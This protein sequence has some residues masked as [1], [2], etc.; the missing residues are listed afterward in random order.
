MLK[1][2]LDITL[3]GIM[4]IVLMPLWLSL[5]LLIGIFEGPPVL[6]R[7]QRVGR[8]GRIFTLYKFR[9]M[10]RGADQVGPGVTMGSDPRVTRFGGFL[11]RS[12][13]DEVPQLLN[14]LCGDMSLV[15][16][17]PEDP[18]FVRLYSPA[19]RRVLE[20][21]PGITSPASLA[22]RHEQQQ[23]TGRT[24]RD[25]VE[26][27]LP[28]KLALELAYLRKSSMASDLWVMLRTAA[29][30]L[31][32]DALRSLIRRYPRSLI[33]R[34]LPWIVID[35]IT[36]V[37]AF[38][39]ALGIRFSEATAAGRP[40][41]TSALNLVIAPLVILFLLVN[42]S[43]G[44]NR[45]VWSYASAGEVM[46]VLNSCA[47][48]T[49]LAVAVD[50][51]I[52]GFMGGR[53]LPL[54]VIVLGGFFTFT[55]IIVTRYRSRLIQAAWRW[56]SQ[57][58]SSPTCTLIYGAGEAGQFVAWRLLH[59]PQGRVY[60]VVGLIDDDHAKRG[61]RVHGLSV[62]GSRDQLHSI[63]DKYQVDLVIL[64]ISNISGDSL[65][66]IV[67]TCQQT[68]A[69]IKIVPNL[70]D[71]M[72]SGTGPLVREITIEDLL[73]RP[74]AAI[75]RNACASLLTGQVVLVT[76]GS[77]SVGSELCRQI[78]SFAPT[79]LVVL[80][81]NES[82]LYD[83]GIELQTSYP[84]LNFDLVVGDVTDE[85][86]MDVILARSRPSVVFHAAA[87]KHVPLMQAF[88]DQ[89]VRANV[90]GTRVMLEAA[91]RHSIDRFVL[92]STDKAVNPTSA[93]GA[94][95]RVAE[96]LVLASRGEPGRTLSTVV[97]F[98][99]VL[100]S[101]GSVV[102]TFARQIELGGP[103][104]V[105]DPEMTRFFMEISDAASLIILAATLTEGGDIFMLEM[106]KRIR[107]D[108]LARKMIRLRGLRPDVDIPI[109]Y[110]G[111]RPGEKFDE[112]LTL[113]GESVE[114]TEHPMIYRVRTTATLA[115][116]HVLDEID[117]LLHQVDHLLRDTLVGDDGS[118]LEHLLALA[119]APL[120]LV[121]TSPDRRQALRVTTRGANTD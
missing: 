30:I 87:Y 113:A 85:R 46:L 73:G 47:T 104:T 102:P 97:R 88:P 75:N 116:H 111:V 52:G 27:A 115:Q 67:D 109:V 26:Q 60:R 14:V 92:V 12:K 33:R 84:D 5:A 34:Y 78:G 103:V 16:P 108:D 86:R 68:S 53:V 65:R 69:Q 57:R 35:G 51:I 42:H 66:A 121:E 10:A 71:L 59:Q 80:D 2:G 106:G 96:L 41:A 37:V 72:T 61:L 7:A 21:R 1:R 48:S 40:A 18:R 99:N 9:T 44:L 29:A 76:G 107:I 8:A 110:T 28:A 19:Q 13:L 118:F 31:H 112:E 58:G 79:N 64:A 91:K 38:Y 55:G 4:L 39:G 117:S 43:W 98:G 49:L 90:L 81:S 24:E 94:S 54:S 89:A 3:S 74:S 56:R 32:L 45:R 63:V 11:R 50:L 6:H 70:F 36:V 95:K 100:G 77:G 23:L 22:F 119:Q 93:M 62:L 101:R 25:Y 20:V 120:P 82:G 105:T 83:L 114:Q 15:G 17:R